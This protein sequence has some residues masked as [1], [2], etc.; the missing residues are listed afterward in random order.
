MAEVHLA[1]AR[2]RA[3]FQRLVVLKTIRPQATDNHSV[4]V[5]LTE[6]ARLSARL[7]HPNV[8]QVTEIVE[9]DQGLM[10]VMEYLDGLCLAEAYRAAGGAFTL[11]LRLRVV[12]EV[13][14]GLHYAH[15]LKDYDGRP[16]QLVHR[17]VS[18]QN[19][20]LTYDGRVTLLAFGV[21][22]VSGSGDTTTGI[23]NG[24]LAYM[25]PEQLRGEPLDRRADVFSM[26]CILFEAITNQR[27]WKG[28]SQ[29]QISSSLAEGIVPQL[30]AELP[31][32]PTLRDIVSRATAS[33]RAD[34]YATANE[35]RLAL[36]SCPDLFEEG[37]SRAFARDVGDMLSMVCDERR[38]QRREDI[39]EAVRAIEQRH[40][41]APTPLIPPTAGQA[42]PEFPR[43]ARAP[44][45]S[46]L[47]S[48]GEVEPYD[49]AQSATGTPARAGAPTQTDVFQAR[50]SKSRA[51]YWVA[52]A[53]VTFGAVLVVFGRWRHLRT[54]APSGPS[55]VRAEV[56]AAAR[57]VHLTFEPVPASATV[58]LD[59]RDLGTGKVTQ[60]V[61]PGS[62]HL[63]RV[64][65]D[66][67]APVEKTIVP[68]AD[69]LHRIQLSPLAP[70]V[71]SHDPV[72]APASDVTADREDQAPA[73]KAT[74]A[75]RRLGSPRPAAVSG[76]RSKD[77]AT[78]NCDPP[79]HFSGGI[80]TYKPECI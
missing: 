62:E 33:S 50:S 59:G 2:R 26:G 36:E 32:D 27:M 15:E 39:A 24:R 30:N 11:P 38:R 17:Y 54:D 60:Q 28:A 40:S 31:I 56:H 79:Y 61:P 29:G 35:M 13:L 22:K 21:A 76:G 10:L 12:C 70:S 53:L 80:K 44:D 6:E 34:R 16:L 67:F 8:V 77:T 52:A 5:S 66:G 63:I 78:P 68:H 47:S 43:P 57:A 3:D 9:V 71:G 37:R 18:P 42:V 7:S 48:W 4:R 1:L 64:V 74:A 55:P 23:V 45:L 14:A 25:S 19:I 41:A 49:A 20:F 51:T 58:F 46:D 65:A 72:S 75:A 69:S 73:P